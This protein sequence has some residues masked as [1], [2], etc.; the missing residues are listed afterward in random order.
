MTPFVVVVPARYASTR[1]PGKALAEIGGKPMV[2]HVAERAALSGASAVYVATDDERMAGGRWTTDD[3]RR[4]TEEFIRP[5]P[6][7][8]SS[9][10][11][12]SHRP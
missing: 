7:L 11:V 6:C 1:F 2:V 8:P 5:Q 10:D 12:D 4:A 9:P 3:G